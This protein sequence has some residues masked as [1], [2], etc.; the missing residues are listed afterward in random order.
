MDRFAKEAKIDE[1]GDATAKRHTT[2]ASS[3]PRPRPAR[4][5]TLRN[6]SSVQVALSAHQQFEESIMFL[7]HDLMRVSGDAADADRF[8]W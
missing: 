4:R 7:R 8:F 1:T 6:S 5:P 2:M 3:P